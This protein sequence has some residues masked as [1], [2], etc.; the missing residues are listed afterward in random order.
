MDIIIEH[1]GTEEHLQLVGGLRD[2]IEDELGHDTEEIVK[3]LEST[4]TLYDRDR[5]VI[6]I[7]T[8]L[9]TV[10]ELAFYINISKED[11]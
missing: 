11:D 1:S 7:F 9:P 5:H 4:I 8:K 10:Q 3:N 2:L 6:G